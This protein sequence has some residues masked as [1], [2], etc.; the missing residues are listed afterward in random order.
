[1]IPSQ[2]RQGTQLR[3][4]GGIVSRL[5]PGV[6]NNGHG[7]TTPTLFG[8]RSLQYRQSAILYDVSWYN[9][10]GERLGMG[11]LNGEDL[12]RIARELLEGEVFIILPANAPARAGKIGRDAG[13]DPDDTGID[14][15]HRYAWYAV[16]PGRINYIPFPWEHDKAPGQVLE[17]WR[18]KPVVMSRDDL[19]EILTTPEHE[20]A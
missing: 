11:D 4:S 1:M 3:S 8:L 9:Q 10:A 16:V 19:L 18:G 20:P 12:M 2:Q 14:Y 13:F 7:R 15:I 5:T 6:F 17:A